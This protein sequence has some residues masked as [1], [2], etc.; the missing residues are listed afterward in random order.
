MTYTRPESMEY[1]GVGKGYNDVLFERDG[2]VHSV[3]EL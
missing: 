3:N 1:I 2:K